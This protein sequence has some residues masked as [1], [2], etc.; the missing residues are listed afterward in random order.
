MDLDIWKERRSGLNKPRENDY[1]ECY[2]RDRARMIHSSSFRRLQ[3][4]TQVLGVGESDFYRTRLTHSLEVA[5]IGSG[6]VQQLRKAAEKQNKAEEWL[7]YLPSADLIITICL[8][9]DL[10]HPPFGHGGE[11][12]LN[13]MMKDYGGFEGNGQ[14]LRI[15]YKLDK[16]TENHGMDLTRRSM[17]G[18]LK[19]PV[20]YQEVLSEKHKSQEFK[21]KTVDSHR[22]VVADH[23]KPPKCYFDEDSEVVEWILSPFGKDDRKKFS[24]TSDAKS[25]N[26]HKKSIYKSFDTSIMDLSDDI[27]Y[28]VHD[29]E[30]AISLKLVT[31]DAWNSEVLPKLKGTGAKFNKIDLDKLTDKLFSEKHYERKEAIGGLVNWLITAAYV[32]EKPEFENPLL[33]YSIKLSEEDEFALDIIKDFVIDRVIKST[34]VQILE[35]KGQQMVMS[36]FEAL[37][38]DPSR[39][40]PVTTRKTWDSYR[41]THDCEIGA[42]VVCDYVS[43]MTDDY[44]SRIYKALF[45]AGDGSIFNRL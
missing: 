20:P 9:H 13:Y 11:I 26:K 15:L 10:G 34:E 44:A 28:G 12:A 18:I 38:S 30:D 2:E 42:R 32:D 1:R 40:L 4:K 35:Y 33:R 22:Q 21:N 27:A 17:L 19:Y 45:V 3:S 7:E 14:T 8:A 31:K 5:Q 16:Y 25:N 29:L 23:W 37:S 43:G 6:I 36:I 41:K 24:E 39:L